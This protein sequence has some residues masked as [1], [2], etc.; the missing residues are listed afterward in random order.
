MDYGTALRELRES[1]CITQEEAA[2]MLG[3]S[4]TAVYRIENNQV[5]D[6]TTYLELYSRIFD[7]PVEQIEAK[8][9][10]YE[11]P[12]IEILVRDQHDVRFY[13]LPEWIDDSRI[14]MRRLETALDLLD[15]TPNSFCKRAKISKTNYYRYKREELV[16]TPIFVRKV[17]K[18]L[19]VRVEDLV[20]TDL[21]VDD[22]LKISQK[23]KK[24]SDETK[25]ASTTPILELNLLNERGQQILMRCYRETLKR[26]PAEK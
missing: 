21:P 3:V 24:K 10:L 12:N 11:T 22:L 17:A 8:A 5:K 15:E 23:T 13:S 20:N 16:P 1:R 19:H 26:Y 25:K 9:T 2:S 6:L 4:G 18:A 14:F 7:I